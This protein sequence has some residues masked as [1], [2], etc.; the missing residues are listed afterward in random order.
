MFSKS[1]AKFI[2]QLAQKK[3]RVQHGLFVVEGHKSVHEFIQSGYTPKELY[4]TNAASFE[5]HE[6]TVV[7]SY[8]MKS[9]SHLKT[10]SNA[11]AV[12]TMPSPSTPQQTDFILALDGIQDPGNMG[13]LIRLCDWFGVKDLV[14]SHD[15]VDCYNPKVV[16]AT[17]GS[18]ARVGVHYV[19][20]PHWL[21]SQK[22]YTT[23][24]AS[25]SG[26]SVYETSI[27]T[28]TILVVGNEGQG[29]SDAVASQLQKQVSIPR[30]GRAESLNAAMAAGILMGEITRI[31]TI[32]K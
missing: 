26:T 25:M 4:V 17:M 2:Q 1:R 24:G 11:L 31:Q 12:F 8:E 15:T 28:P 18:L 22:N 19:D 32:Q 5:N 10:P 21:A 27:T 20:L 14:C 7:K 30:Y 13:T 16:R 3:Q 6:A 29:L 23:V 9:L